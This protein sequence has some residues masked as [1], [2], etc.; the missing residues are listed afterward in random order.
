M[1]IKTYGRITYKDLD[2]ASVKLLSDLC[3]ELTEEQTKE[4]QKEIFNHYQVYAKAPNSTALANSPVAAV[5]QIILVKAYSKNSDYLVKP[6]H[7]HKLTASEIVQACPKDKTLIQKAYVQE[8]KSIQYADLKV[9]EDLI[10][11]PIKLEDA[12]AVFT[13]ASVRQK[14]IARAYSKNSDHLL[15]LLRENKIAAQEFVQACSQDKTV[16]KEAYAKEPKSIQYANHYILNELIF[17]P[18]KLEDA[19]AITA[20]VEKRNRLIKSAYA[21]NPKQVLQLLQDNLLAAADLVQALPRE[22]SVIKAAFAK[23]ALSINYASLEVLLDLVPNPVTHEDL[24]RA[25]SEEVQHLRIISALIDIKKNESLVWHMVSKGLLNLQE[26]IKSC[27]KNDLVIKEVYSKDK[28]L[29][30]HA[31]VAGVARLL[32]NPIDLKD[33]LTAFSAKADRQ[34]LISTAYTKN[35]ALVVNLLDEG[36]VLASEIICASPSDSTVIKT[37]YAKDSMSIAF[38]NY[39]VLAELLFNPIKLEDALAALT[40]T[41]ARRTVLLKAYSTNKELVLQQVHDN[42]LSAKELVQTFPNDIDFVK[43]AYAKDPKSL[44]YAALPVLK[45]LLPQWAEDIFAVLADDDKEYLIRFLYSSHED[46]IWQLVDKKVISPIE[47]IQA[48]PA[49]KEIVKT[50]YDKDVSSIP[51]AEQSLVEDLIPSIISFKA[52][53]KAFEENHDESNDTA[54]SLTDLIRSVFYRDKEQV[55]QMVSDGTITA[56]LLVKALPSNNEAIQIAYSKD[57]KSILHAEIDALETHT[58]TPIS[59]HEVL[60]LFSNN[61]FV[62]QYLIAHVYFKDKALVLQMVSDDLVDANDFIKALL[63][64]PEAVKIAYKKDPRSI[65][66]ADSFVVAELIPHAIS[67][68]DALKTEDEYAKNR[69]IA[70][71]FSKDKASI[72]QMIND[73]ILAP[74]SLVKALPDN[75]EAIKIAYGQ[76]R[77][78]IKHANTSTLID[79]IFN[80]ISLYEVLTW[81]I[82]VHEKRRIIREV[83][84]KN[85]EAVVR[86]LQE[87]EISPDL[88][89]SAVPNVTELISMAYEKDHNSIKHANPT[90][91]EKLIPNPIALIDALNAFSLYSHIKRSFITQCYLKDKE[92]V[93]KLLRENLLSPSE[94]LQIYPNESE[95]IRLVYEKDRTLL[96]LASPDC[97]LKLIGAP[98]EPEEAIKAFPTN[99]AIIKAVYALDPA[100]IREANSE[101]VIELI[102]T[103]I[104]PG[105]AIK[106]FPNNS[107][108]LSAACLKDNSLLKAVSSHIAL[109]LVGKGVSPA[110]AIKAHPEDE[111]LVRA[112]YRLKPLAVE[113]AEAG[114]VLNL[115]KAGLIVP[116]LAQSIFPD[117]KALSDWIAAMDLNTK[118]LIRSE[119]ELTALLK[120]GLYDP[121]LAVQHHPKSW[122]IVSAAYEIDTDCI[123][124]ANKELI[125]ELGVAQVIKKEHVEQ[126]FSAH[127]PTQEELEEITKDFNK[128]KQEKNWPQV[129]AICKRFWFEKPPAAS[130]KEVE[131]ELGRSNLWQEF[132]S[133]AQA[134]YTEESLLTYGPLTKVPETYQLEQM[135]RKMMT[136]GDFRIELRD[137]EDYFVFADGTRFNWTRIQAC[138]DLQ[139]VDLEKSDFALYKSFL[140]SGSSEI[141]S[142]L[143]PYQ[144]DTYRQKLYSNPNE[145]LQNA[146]KLP[147]PDDAI[148]FQEMQAIN[149]F[150]GSF[151]EQMNGLM[152]DERDRF[153]YTKGRTEKNKSAREETLTTIRS[154]I[155]H[156]VMAASGLRKIPEVVI[157]QTYRGG[158]HGSIDVQ[159]ER[160]RTAAQKGLFEMQG[161]FST[162]LDK[163]RAASFDK[164]LFYK[165]TNLRGA[166]VAPISSFDYEQEYLIPQAQFQVTSYQRM[167]KSSHHM[168]VSVVSDLEFHRQK[169]QRFEP[170]AIVYPGVD[171]ELSAIVLAYDASGYVD[172]SAVKALLLR[173]CSKESSYSSET[174]PAN[175]LLERLKGDKDLRCAV[176][177]NI[178][179]TIVSSS[180]EK[181]VQII[182]EFMKNAWRDNDEL[183][184]TVLTVQ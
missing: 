174:E 115:V 184:T 41:I 13:D 87:N 74:A 166:Y 132:H 63:R 50:A 62:K 163:T 22:Q 26:V 158:K 83:Y 15:Q 42:T 141:S 93:L 137:G 118:V 142:T 17:T 5:R 23:E 66:Y 113:Y 34:T 179:D 20:D 180:P 67:L 77:T 44:E 30:K 105:V 9:L 31:D 18:I 53:V 72:V 171:K 169:G 6:L 69:Y 149:I 167:T 162:S 55:A 51:F 159:K 33:A 150:T 75:H 139:Q 102:G 7:E 85:K 106:L 164:G 175:Y 28:T 116:M 24:F 99:P 161:F 107:Q 130:V 109:S 21:K 57:S 177:L 121:Y 170:V 154:A 35:S 146:V 165:I 61:D 124:G 47:V 48:F 125:N 151:Y 152:R 160:V 129:A 103:D 133:F 11:T 100:L 183:S 3:I 176:G 65:Q 128:A 108:I 94:L 111:N 52:L 54:F 145:K 70:Q 45:M 181:V 143:D 19:L 91:V 81:T 123:K 56:E 32:F 172:E 2:K 114:T 157:P 82:D 89:L 80:P 122:E 76:D 37:A 168:D 127:V 112:M 68:R 126:M 131:S 95:V 135:A 1:K 59:L 73:G 43:L 155:V 60:S 178:E 79:L 120:Q 153:N 88:V 36:V 39:S 16:L 8:P 134:F 14:L 90:C 38:A 101:A 27:P 86:A 49:N 140:D 12:L 25:F 144:E 182:K 10:L 78:S 29:I 156:S 117:N 92:Q 97:I 96:P 98:I 46:L 147:K 136:E 4:L 71:A 138:A 110:E 104:D 119:Q 40:N 58:P 84:A 148:T 64:D 173:L